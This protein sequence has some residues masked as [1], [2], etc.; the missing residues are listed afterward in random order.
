MIGIYESIE[1]DKLILLDNHRDAWVF[2]GAD[3]SSGTIV[4][5]E[6]WLLLLLGSPA[7]F[8][9]HIDSQCLG[10]QNGILVK[11]LCSWDAEEFGLATRIN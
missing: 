9:V 6:L 5:M 1:P 3:P 8:V 7:L 11:L 10:R 2:E 4:L